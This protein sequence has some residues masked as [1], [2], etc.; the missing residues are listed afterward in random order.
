MTSDLDDLFQEAKRAMRLT[1]GKLPPPALPDPHAL[2]TNPAN[3]TRGRNLALVHRETGTLMGLFTEYSHRTER[4]TRKLVRAA[5]IQSIDSTE[6]FDG[7]LF[8]PPIP[9]VT[10]SRLPWHTALRI[11][12]SL[13]ISSMQVESSCSLLFRFGAGCLDSIKLERETLFSNPSGM[14]MQL[15]AGTDLLPQLTE[16]EIATLLTLLGFKL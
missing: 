11:E 8:S 5:D 10:S 16:G 3:W 7:P 13:L 9:K 4:L 6:L 12:T 15:P 1:K 14:Y 2:Y